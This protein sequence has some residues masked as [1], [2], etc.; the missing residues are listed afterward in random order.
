MAGSLSALAGRTSIRFGATC[1]IAAAARGCER[2][3]VTSAGT[4]AGTAPPGVKRPTIFGKAY[5]SAV[6]TAA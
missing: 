5:P 3:A 4:P 6:D 2:K 1:S